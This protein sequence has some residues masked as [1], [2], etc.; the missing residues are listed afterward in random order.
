MTIV[1]NSL[2]FDYVEQQ[3]FSPARLAD[4][5]RVS[6]ST[7]KRW[8]DRGLLSGT[9]TAGGHRKIALADVVVFLRSHGGSIPDLET[10]AL[11]A[12]H[13]RPR[14]ADTVSADELADLFVK[15]QTDAARTLVLAQFTAGRLVEEILDQLI[16]P[17]MAQVGERWAAGAIDVYEEHLATQRCAR[18]LGELGQLMPAPS[19][20]AP[21]A[22]GGAPEDD[23]YILPTLMAE[24][25]LRE[26]RW[27][28]L[29]LGPDVP[30]ASFGEA[31]ARHHPR[32]VWISITSNPLAPTFLA[33]YPLAYEAARAHGAAVILGGQGLT[34]SLAQTMLATAFGSRLTHLKALAQVLDS[35]AEPAGQ[36]HPAASNP[37][38]DSARDG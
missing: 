24:L 13:S 15:G 17:A 7:V 35:R 3:R 21:L 1:Q 38:V 36:A 5:L 23:P 4:I 32:L 14:G 27:R 20:T 10:L 9:K 18:V 22:L 2:I 19:E 37:R 6:E 26:L 30:A 34:P 8:V 12:G 29:N 33:N 25:T 28:T 16:G 31:I 11:L